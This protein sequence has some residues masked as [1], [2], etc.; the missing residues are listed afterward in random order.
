MKIGESYASREAFGKALVELADE[1]PRLAVFD[2]D[3]C[4]S[5]MTKYFRDRYPE[6]FYQMG[7]AEANMIGAAAG[8]AST[9]WT[10]F[11]STFAVFLA[12]RATDQIRVSVA[13]ANLDVKLNGAYGGLPTGRAGATHSAVEDIAIMRAMPNMKVLVPAD[14][15]ETRSAVRLALDTPGPVYLRTVRC[16]VPVIFDESHRMRLGVGTVLAEGKDAAIVSTGM[17]T[18]RCLEAARSLEREGIRVRHIHMGSVKPIDSELLR[19]AARDCG[20]I[21]TVENHGVTGGL[22]GAVA[23]TTAELEPCRVIRVGFPDV[24]LESGDDESIFRKYGMDAEGIA[25]T[26]RRALG[27]DAKSKGW[28]KCAS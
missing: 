6:R 14:P 11:V 23:E 19:A 13:H 17:M 5:T 20:L 9:G 18:P 24:F 28:T 12:T 25:A 10:P 21:V 1:Y 15:A 16:A 27:A 3:V 7:I 4:A 2:A 22:G 8:M 26:V